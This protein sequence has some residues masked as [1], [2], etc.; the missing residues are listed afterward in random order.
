MVKF[1]SVI[2]YNNVLYSLGGSW[3]LEGG[4]KFGFVLGYL[5]EYWDYDG[6]IIYI[7]LLFKFIVFGE[8][9]YFKCFVKEI[10]NL[11]MWLLNVS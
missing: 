8:R 5:E 2:I 7:E 1:L 4:I 9:V 6:L 3:V 11:V 10:F